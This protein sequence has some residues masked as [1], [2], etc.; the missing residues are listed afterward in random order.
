MSRRLPSLNALRCF[1][2]VA[3]HLSIKKA[4][5]TLHVSESAVSRQ[6]RILE[7]Q[8]G[9]P[10]FIRTH[11]GLEITEAGQRLAIGVKEAFDHIAEAI[12]PFQSD[13]DAVT[14]RVLPTFALRWLYPR[15]RK[16]QAQ[17][18]LLRVNVQTRINDM[19]FSDGD[20]D[21]GIR[22]G[23]G[24][25]PAES[26]TELYPEW[27]LP[28]CAPGYLPSGTLT[29]VEDF[30]KITLLHPLPN[31]QDW[32]IWSERSGFGRF[33]TRAGLD[34]DALDMALSAAEAG[35]GIAMTDVVLAHDSIES[36]RLVAPIRQPVPTGMSYF[37]V[38]PPDLKRK[39][40]VKLLDEW[41]CD[42]ISDA[43]KVVRLYA[44]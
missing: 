6:I 19:N 31:R 12:N 29:G 40:Q 17:H 5:T 22:Y 14:I 8:L 18:P 25:W 41:I 44:H 1:E 2:V 16:F 30:A 43:R 35:F 32:T 26:A 11:N 33:D 24:N 23:L 10:L 20:A 9:V 15:L 42:E 37:L 27:I 7:Q 21:L 4:A 3:G 39:R 28:V 13:R 34:F 38:R 36:G